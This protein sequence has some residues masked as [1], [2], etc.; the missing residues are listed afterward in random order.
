M[1][2]KINRF[3]QILFYRTTTKFFNH[4]NY[5]VISEHD[6]KFKLFESF[7]SRREKYKV[8]HIMKF[9]GNINN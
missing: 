9:N 4:M 3:Y 2:I 5:F 1:K 7:L 6:K 8:F